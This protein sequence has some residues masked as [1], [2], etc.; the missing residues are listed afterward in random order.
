MAFSNSALKE[1][2]ST[3]SQNPR[4]IPV[5]TNYWSLCRPLNAGPTSKLHRVT[6]V[7]VQLSFVYL[8]DR[9]STGSVIWDIVS[10]YLHS[11]RKEMHVLFIAYFN[12]RD[13]QRD[14]C[15]CEKTKN[16]T[17]CFGL[18]KCLLFLKCR[19]PFALNELW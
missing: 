2:K 17:Y 13:S 14:R 4:I 5:T 16:I 1:T 3:R 6:K 19:H 8:K 15:Y 9:N 18:A 10:K 11:Y 12:L 7:H